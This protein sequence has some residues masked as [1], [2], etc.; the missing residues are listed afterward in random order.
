MALPVLIHLIN[1]MRHRRVKWAA[2]DFLLQSQKRHK[3]WIILKQLLLLLTRMGAI[4]AVAFMVAQP[5]VR[6][7]WGEL[8][9]GAQTHH[10]VLLDDSF[11]MADRDG[12]TSAFERAKQVVQRLAEQAGQQGS[13]HSFSLIRFSSAAYPALGGQ[14]EIVQQPING[15]LLVQ[16]EK[17]LGN[18]QPSETAASAVS[19]L[20]ATR[21]LPSKSEDENRLVY[22]VSDFRRNDWNEPNELRDML[23]EMA[24]DD[25]KINLVHCVEAERPNLA[26]TS[27]KPLEGIRAAGV[28]MFIEV[29]VKNFGDTAVSEVSVRL[30]ENGHSRPGLVIDKIAPGETVTRRFRV[31]FP[32]AGEHTLAASLAA[33]AVLADNTRYTVVDVPDTVPVLIIDAAPEARDG[34]FIASALAPGGNV[35]TGLAPQVEPLSFLRKREELAK[36]STIYLLN[37]ERL[38][39]SEIEA[40]EQYVEQGGGLAFFL[41]EQSRREFFNEALYRD[42]EGLFPVPLQ[43]PTD[44]LPDRVHRAPDIQASDHP[45]FKTLLAMRHN[46]LDEVLVQRYYTT[47]STWQPPRD[48][49]VQVIAELRNG[50][51]L[52]VEKKYGQGRV[53]A[54]LT[55]ASPLQTSLGTWN[56]WARNHSYL[57]VLLNLQGYL[58]EGQH[59]TPERIVGTPLSVPI[60]A[61]QFQ[62]QVQFKL[63]GDAQHEL[64]IDAAQHEE[65]LTATLAGTGTSG[66]Y[67]ARLS[68]PAG[69]TV[70]RRFAYNVSPGEGDLHLLD[71]EQ[72]APRLAGVQYK[73]HR[74]QDLNYDP[75]DVAGFNLGRTIL[76]ILLGLLICEQLL[77]YSASYHTPRKEVA[78]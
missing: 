40:L 29:S 6:N 24:E 14:Q 55:K 46:P 71:G 65:Q 37:L 50:A 36:F 23:A 31:N 54:F 43:L 57:L 17:Q 25:Y 18:L 67:T 26:I 63:P 73:F 20:E 77:A 70:E 2:M 47:P 39:A 38:D 12:N 9:G 78:R 49:T 69:Q 7:E 1:M 34:F 22:I 3:K 10:V 51:P 33:D 61:E 68:T 19:A 53:V 21:N 32:T 48:S 45:I 35:Q 13:S 8:F 62:P 52:V 27:L 60:D 72:L 11:S 59:V 64:V 30:E 15:D 74:S 56:N 41:G 76:Y 28:E 75:Q 66:I 4:A 16:L 5:I 44:L 58:C 42:G